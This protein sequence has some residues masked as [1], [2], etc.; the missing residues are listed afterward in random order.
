MCESVAKVGTDNHVKPGILIGL[1]YF[2]SFKVRL[3]EEKCCV[4]SDEAVLLVWLTNQ[5][6]LSA[7]SV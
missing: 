5:S 4:G 2:S 6:N 1:L 3:N 7:N